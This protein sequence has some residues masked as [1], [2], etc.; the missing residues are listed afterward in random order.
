MRVQ[1]TTGLTEKEAFR[2]LGVGGSKTRRMLQ[3]RACQVALITGG[4]CISYCKKISEGCCVI[5]I[6]KEALNSKHGVQRICRDVVHS[7]LMEY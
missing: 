6:D 7:I 4:N 1:Q 3:K 5:D 2:I